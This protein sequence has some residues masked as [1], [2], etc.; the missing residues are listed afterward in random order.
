MLVQEAKEIGARQ[1][2]VPFKEVAVS[3]GRRTLW[4]DSSSFGEYG[5]SQP[6]V[7]VSRPQIL[8]GG[9]PA[10][11]KGRFLFVCFC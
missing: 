7:Y 6:F 11:K 9:M 3:C 8:A 10:K 1:L 4:Q 5:I 2:S